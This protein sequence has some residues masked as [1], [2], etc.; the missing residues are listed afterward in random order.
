MVDTEESRH[1]R[2]ESTYWFNYTVFHHPVG[3]ASDK[4]HFYLK[5]DQPGRETLCKWTN[6]SFRRC[7]CGRAWNLKFNSFNQ[8]KLC[9]KI[10]QFSGQ[11]P[12][13]S[14]LESLF[15]PPPLPPPCSGPRRF[16]V[17]L[18]PDG[19]RISLERKRPVHH[20]GG[21]SCA[22]L[23][24]DS[25]TDHACTHTH[26]HGAPYVNGLWLW[27]LVR[28]IRPVYTQADVLKALH[29][30]ALELVWCKQKSFV[31][32]LS[33]FNK[34]ARTGNKQ[35]LSFHA[36]THAHLHTFLMHFLFTHGIKPLRLYLFRFSCCFI[37][38]PKVCL[39]NEWGEN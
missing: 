39:W 31:T 11:C 14:G 32:N 2:N 8:L 37:I 6:W 9:L 5:I 17:F 26:G 10:V 30:H 4:T 19:R 33:S 15:N 21:S 34:Y 1:N 25:G 3:L 16:C 24:S 12:I 13:G 29:I 36:N 7:D 20:R 27:N 28:S 38:I 35:T 22:G 18:W 23:W